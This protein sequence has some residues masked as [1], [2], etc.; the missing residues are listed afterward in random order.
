MKK[1]GLLLLFGLVVLLG[2]LFFN[3]LTIPSRQV[4][5]EGT[6]T[7]IS[8]I[9][10]A[11]QRISQS[12]TY[13]TISYED[14]SLINFAPFIEFHNFLRTSF[15]NIFN[16]LDVELVNEYTMVLHWKG[17]N[18][19]LAPGVILAHMDV[20]P[21]AE[22]T[23]ELWSVPPFEGI[24]KGDTLYGRGAIDN[25]VN[26]MGQMEAIEFLL[27]NNFQPE[28]D[29]YFVFG[30]D[31]EIGGK[32]GALKVAQ[33]MQSRGIKADFVLDEGGFVTN[34]MVPGV[35][36]PVAMIGTSEKGYLNLQLSV[37]IDG[38]HSSMPAKE[39]A[40]AVLTQALTDLNNQPFPPS[41]SPSVKDFIEYIAPHSVFINKLAMS[42]MW[43][44]KPLIYDI[45]SASPAG[46]AMVRTTMVPTIIQ[47]GVK[48]NVIP[49]IVTANIN[50]RL[51]PGTSVADAIA[52]TEKAINNPLIK[53]T[54][55]RQAQEASTVSPSNTASFNNIMNS[56]QLNF[57]NVIVAPFLMIAGT[58]SKHFDIVSPNIYKFSPMTDPTGFHGVNE[59][60]NLKDYKNT[61]GFYVDFI[62]NL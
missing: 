59:F 5:P 24:I 54:A 21:V 49:N 1:I 13:Q 61:I 25:K 30:H 14:T 27:K 10:G 35:N 57:E 48:D 15:P 33:L 47:G 16:H 62:K 37:N 11:E 34:T 8:S 19:S 26:L 3:F 55:T 2:V 38:G 46:N 50:Y 7:D 6:R 9:D 18:S 40:I 56:I 52:H 22:D 60:L 20:V 43:L 17:K 39:N 44:F 29:V 41:I 42:N 23:R 28:R 53:V 32:D 12:I 36:Q 4:A 58:D 51:L 31:E 45:Y